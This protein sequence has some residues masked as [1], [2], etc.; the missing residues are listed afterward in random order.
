MRSRTL[1]AVHDAILEDL[2]F[3]SEIVGKRIRVNLGGSRLIKVHL[4]KVQQNNVEHKVETFSGVYKKLMD[5]DVNFEFPEFQSK[6]GS[7]QPHCLLQ[8]DSD[9]SV[10]PTPEPQPPTQ[11]HEN[12]GEARRLW[13]PEA[14]LKLAPSSPRGPAWA[15]TCGLSWIA[16]HVQPRVRSPPAP[17]LARRLG[18]CQLLQALTPAEGQGMSVGAVLGLEAAEHI[19]LCDAAHVAWLPQ[20]PFP[21]L[22]MG[23]PASWRACAGL[24]SVSSVK[25]TT[26]MIV[27]G[28]M[29][30][31]GL[32]RLAE[33]T[34]VLFSPG[35]GGLTISP[36]D[37]LAQRFM[38]PRSLDQGGSQGDLEHV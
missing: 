20:P 9:T 15:D 21:S 30:D 19:P 12:A 1:T 11:S 22:G 6:G 10:P 13:P 8:Q 17:S 24:L 5:K 16:P 36:E 23:M 4:D 32:G 38:S 37:P 18:R 34:Y 2:V 3:P 28:R 33:D 26:T 14:K 35:P 7:R 29:T 25:K 31:F 27:I